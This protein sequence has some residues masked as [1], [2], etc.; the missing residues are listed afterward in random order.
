MSEQ[1]AEHDE[2]GNERWPSY[3][4]PHELLRC[5]CG[6]SEMACRDY[7]SNT[8][9]NDGDCSSLLAH[10]LKIDVVVSAHVFERALGGL[11]GRRS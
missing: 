2:G 11:V 6:G 9:G 3:Q 4:D 10:F 1:P 8:S 7:T 5:S